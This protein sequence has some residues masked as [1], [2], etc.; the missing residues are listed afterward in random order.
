MALSLTIHLRLLF[1]ALLI[2]AACA[3]AQTGFRNLTFS[4]LRNPEPGYYLIEPNASDSIGFVDHSGRTVCR[5]LSGIHSNVQA[6]NNTYITHF[7]SN[8]NGEP[9]CLRR[10]RFLNVIDTL[11]STADYYVDF[12]EGKVW[13]D[14]TYLILA[15]ENRIMDLSGV[16]P[17]GSPSASIIG[18]VIQERKVSNGAV[19]FEWKSVDHI[20]VTQ[21]M[22]DTELTDN[23]IDYTHVNSASKD[24]DGILIV[25]CRHLDEVIKINKSTGEILWRLGGSASKSNQFAFLS[26]NCRY[27]YTNSDCAS[28]YFGTVVRCVMVHH[29]KLEGPRMTRQSKTMLLRWEQSTV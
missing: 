24:T 4:I 10:N 6:Y 7:A 20:P 15:S 2:G 1:V 26:N 23:L 16:V 3:S 14:S 12:H 21:A 25:S 5:T 17:G 13:S 19:V 22:A 29:Q 11:R 18:A 27:C 8:T 28:P 9:Y